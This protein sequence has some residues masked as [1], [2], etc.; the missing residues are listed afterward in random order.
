MITPAAQTTSHASTASRQRVLT[1]LGSAWLGL[2][3]AA[4]AL[5]VT[6]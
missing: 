3:L 6:A 2:A 4:T 1:L 5:A